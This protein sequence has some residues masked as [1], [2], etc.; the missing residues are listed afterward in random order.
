VGVAHH[1]PHACEAAFFEGSD[2]LAPEALGFAVAHL[3]AQQLTA[4]VG[5]DAHGH[6]H[7]PR[8]DLQGLAQ[9]PVEIRCVKV[10]VGVAGLL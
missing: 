2:E 3:E 10:D 9:P 8:A 4:A 1:Q 7:S 6:H 5:I